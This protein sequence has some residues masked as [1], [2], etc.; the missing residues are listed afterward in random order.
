MKLR[1]PDALC[2]AILGFA[3][4]FNVFFLIDFFCCLRA[5]AG[6]E[7]LK[8]SWFC[9]LIDTK[10]ASVFVLLTIIERFIKFT[11][12]SI[13]ISGHL[14]SLLQHPACNCG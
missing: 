14:S 6:H 8:E 3:F 7:G 12:E 4:S 13:R 5:G 2:F 1:V 11:R 9:F 10:F